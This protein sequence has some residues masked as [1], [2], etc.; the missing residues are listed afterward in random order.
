VFSRTDLAD[1]TGIDLLEAVRSTA[2]SLPFVLVPETGSEAVASESISAGV[3]DY[4]RA[5]TVVNHADALAR[6]ILDAVEQYRSDLIVDA[7]LGA[8]A[9]IANRIADVNFM[10]DGDWDR[11]L[12]VSDAYES[13]WGGSIEALRADPREFLEHVHPQDRSIATD[14]M[15]R[16]AAGEPTDVQYRIET[17]DGGYRWIRGVS[18]PITDGGGE[19]VRIAGTVRDVSEVKE[20]DRQLQV[21]ARVLRHNLHNQMNLVLGLAESIEHDTEEPTTATRAAQILETGTELLALTDKQKRI[22]EHV[23]SSVEIETVDIAAV[24]DH[25]IASVA[26]EHETVAFEVTSPDELLVVAVP[27]I[28]S[29]IEELLENAVV[30]A[31]APTQRI[32]VEVVDAGDVAEVRIDDENPPIPALETQILRGDAKI[33]QLTHGRG[34]G[35]WLVSWLV[36]KSDGTIAFEAG[37]SQGNSISVRLPTTTRREDR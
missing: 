32:G 9:E 26:A 1:A 37:E 33:D 16:L 24:V 15:E 3:T 35:L 17:L 4:V 36:E 14:S 8:W 21:L 19:V 6:R 27:E 10:F 7:T 5:A 22:V 18:T 20:R 11:C 34:L 12:Y 31:A 30:H 28:E 23:T 13:L 25:C 29:A 2:P